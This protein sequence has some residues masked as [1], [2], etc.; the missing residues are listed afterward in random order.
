MI[1]SHP[2]HSNQL[3]MRADT[4]RGDCA[5]VDVSAHTCRWRDASHVRGVGNGGDT[6]LASLHDLPWKTSG[7]LRSPAFSPHS[8]RRGGRLHALRRASDCLNG[9]RRSLATHFASHGRGIAARLGLQFKGVCQHAFHG[10][11]D[12][13]P[14]CVSVSQCTRPFAS[15]DAAKGI[16][17][18]RFPV[19]EVRFA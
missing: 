19:G 17:S 13:T 15:N 9:F 1:H 18:V 5:L 3:Q 11:A 10:L 14:A 12:M 4:A 16:G 6:V 8:Q 7:R 2:I